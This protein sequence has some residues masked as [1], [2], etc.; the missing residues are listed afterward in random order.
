MTKMETTDFEGE[1]DFL[2]SLKTVFTNQMDD[3]KPEISLSQPYFG[4]NIFVAL[5][6][7]SCSSP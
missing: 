5:Y 1:I 7:L 3:F 6:I 2:F 4:Y